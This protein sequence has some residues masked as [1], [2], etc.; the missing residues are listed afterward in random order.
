MGLVK[1]ILPL[2]RAVARLSPRVGRPLLGSALMHCHTPNTWVLRRPPS[3]KRRLTWAEEA[4]AVYQALVETE[5][6][7]PRHRDLL[8]RALTQHALALL[9]VGRYEQAWTT[10]EASLAVPGARWSPAQW[11][12]LLHLQAEVQF[13]LGRYDEALASAAE[14]VAA[15]RRL[16]PTRRER[17]LGRLP[18]ALHTYALVLGALGRTNESVAAHEE[19]AG[20]LRAMSPW[21]LLQ[22]S[23][24][25]TLRPR[26]L[27][28]LTVGFFGLGRFEEAL[29]V[30]QEA[31]EAAD[32]FVIWASPET[33]R[34]LRIQI[35][36][37]LALCYEVTGDLPTARTTAT[38]AVAA[39]R[40]LTDRHPAAGELLTLVLDSLADLLGEPEE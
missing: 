20:L 26:V 10:I 11:A 6:P 38:E 18:R 39:A 21:D 37:L 40:A 24:L 34:P 31:R 33:M 8:A 17:V 5:S 29:T 22:L 16:V 1:T 25:A 13:N 9:L 12:S 35:L 4:V 7:R 19:C 23:R 36:A 32:P 2:P 14:C 30:G 15:Y 28:K 27:F 3:P